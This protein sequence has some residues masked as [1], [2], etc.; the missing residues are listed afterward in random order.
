MIKGM[1][2]WGA[3]LSKGS[4]RRTFRER[5]AVAHK[6]LKSVMGGGKA[7]RG[8][9]HGLVSRLEGVNLVLSV[10]GCQWW[11]FCVWVFF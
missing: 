2:G 9:S 3:E 11:V 7:R 1:W 6:L 10:L 4:A 5:K 8:L